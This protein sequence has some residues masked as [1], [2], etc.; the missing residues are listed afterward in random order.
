MAMNALFR[1]SRLGSRF[2]LKRIVAAMRSQDRGEELLILIRHLLIGNDGKWLQSVLPRS[3]DS[4]FKR[5][6]DEEFLEIMIL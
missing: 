2:T 6:L 5:Q 3:A 1:N 4:P